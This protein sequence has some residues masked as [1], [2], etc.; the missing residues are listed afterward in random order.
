MSLVIPD[1][2]QSRYNFEQQPVAA[3]LW[4]AYKGR[5][6]GDGTHINVPLAELLADLGKPADE[7]WTAEL[8]RVLRSIYAAYKIGYQISGGTVLVWFTPEDAARTR[9]YTHSEPEDGFEVDFETVLGQPALTVAAHGSA[10]LKLSSLLI[11]HLG[12]DELTEAQ[13]SELAE[14]AA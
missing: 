5:H 11:A 13:L 2:L 7:F 6:D 8:E 12:F 9:T 4:K 1:G 3:A 14:V 10:A